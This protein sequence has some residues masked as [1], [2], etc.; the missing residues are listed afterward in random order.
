MGTPEKIEINVASQD[1]QKTDNS[2]LSVY[3][4]DF[5]KKFRS[6][7]S[8]E[9]LIAITGVKS[10]I[11]KDEMLLTSLLGQLKENRFNI[12]FKGN[13]ESICQIGIVCKKYHQAHFI[14]F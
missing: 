5:V 9:F 14:Q 12:E 2:F 7:N 3:I 4:N 6:Y 10:Y 11:D 1:C 13:E 8:D